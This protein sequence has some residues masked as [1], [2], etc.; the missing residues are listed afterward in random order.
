[1]GKKKKEE[2]REPWSYQDWYDKNKDGLSQR[3]KDRY[4]TDPEYKERVLEQNKKYREKKRKEAAQIPRPKVRVPRH[5]RPVIRTIL[6]RGKPKT[7]ELVH[8]GAFA[9]I[10]GKSV[11]TIHQWERLGLLPR[12]P[13]YVNGKS[14][15]ERLFTSEMIEVV[16]EAVETRDR[17]IS[18]K[19]PTFHDE[20]VKGW[21][22]HGV[23]E[24]SII[25][26]ETE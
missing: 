21:K 25:V 14:K 22:K 15:R 13:F 4:H 19:D 24:D 26:E 3:R 11:P 23:D 8:V 10:V 16:K 9:R 17:K 6:L 7:K 5:R 18:S 2:Q 1:M 20:I 12:T